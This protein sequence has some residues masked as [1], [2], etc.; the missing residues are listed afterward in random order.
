MSS[1][2]R[3]VNA[4]TPAGVREQSVVLTGE[5]RSS[6]RQLRTTL[7]L[8]F[9]RWASGRAGRSDWN[10]RWRSTVLPCRNVYAHGLAVDNGRGNWERR[11]DQCRGCRSHVESVDSRGE[12]GALGQGRLVVNGRER[13]VMLEPRGKGIP[14]TTLR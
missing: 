3:A 7:V 14:A 6:G 12:A 10:R 1:R 2:P 11:R 4:F 8:R 5:F 13:I 9:P